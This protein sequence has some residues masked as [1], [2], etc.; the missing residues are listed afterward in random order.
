MNESIIAVM[1][2]RILFF[3]IPEFHWRV[4]IPRNK[5]TNHRTMT[6][7]YLLP[8]VAVEIIAVILIAD[9]FP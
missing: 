5:D 9:I 8:V 2:W 1:L 6:D 3:V 4:V 7:R